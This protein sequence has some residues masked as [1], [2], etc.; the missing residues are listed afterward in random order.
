[1]R[2]I[3][4]GSTSVQPYAEI[5]AEAYCD[6]YPEIA[7][8]IQG[9]GSSAGGTAAQTGTADIGMSSRAL[10]QQ[11]E[12]LYV[13]EIAKDG[14]AI[15]VNPANPINNLTL[16]QVSAIYSQRIDNWSSLGG[17]NAKIHVIAREDGSG[18][19]SAFVD[20]VMHNSK[21]SPRAIVQDSNGAVRQLVADDPNAIGFISLGLVDIG[22]RPVKALSLDGVAATHDNV[23][24]GSYN[25]T[26]P[27]I[28]VTKSEPRG[29][30]LDFI[31]YVLSDEGRRIL[32]A[33]GLVVD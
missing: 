9:G 25:L 33:E 5:L 11:E 30:T 27:F 16:E 13:I 3:V 6:M 24:N 22:E 2:I 15:I 1:M 21:I 18:T 26:R 4:A 32:L 7:V 20:L 8:D 10:N 19:R 31:N 14:L 28:F 23:V 29:I 17:N 12:G